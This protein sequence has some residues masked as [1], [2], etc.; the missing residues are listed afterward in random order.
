M[1]YHEVSSPINGNS[2]N[3]KVLLISSGL[4][5]TTPLIASGKQKKEGNGGDDFRKAAQE[6]DQ[7]AQIAEANAKIYKKLANIKRNAAS[8][9]DKGEWKKIDWTE[10]KTLTSQLNF[11]GK[12][13]KD[14]PKK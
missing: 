10:Y 14:M 4:L 8:L 6:H 5:F 13:H 12:K 9:A 2:M 11:G 1:S 7:K 3:I